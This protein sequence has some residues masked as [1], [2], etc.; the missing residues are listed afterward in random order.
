MMLWFPLLYII[1]CAISLP[2]CEK[3]AFFALKYTP[4]NGLKID[5][6]FNSIKLCQRKCHQYRFNTSKYIFK[7]RFGTN[8]N[9]KISKLSKFRKKTIYR[10][11][12][13]CQNKQNKKKFKDI[14]KKLQFVIR[15]RPAPPKSHKKHLTQ[16]FVS[17][18][19]HRSLCHECIS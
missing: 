19:R 11:D 3:D 6:C 12:M 10:I 5:L 1:C 15:F 14:F 16:V 2:K 17:N 18:R 7:R 4:Q 8:K 13:C 9:I